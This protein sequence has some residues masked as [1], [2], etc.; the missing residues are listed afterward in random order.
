MDKAIHDIDLNI[1]PM[2][3]PSYYYYKRWI[4]MMFPWAC[5]QSDE[6]FT[7][8]GLINQCY[9]NKLRYLSVDED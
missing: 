3:P 4:W 1:D 2:I 6:I 5:L 8:S 7:F 9:S